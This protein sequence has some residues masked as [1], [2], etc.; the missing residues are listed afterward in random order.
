M[1][2]L[3]LRVTFIVRSFSLTRLFNLRPSLFSDGDVDG[4]SV[5]LILWFSSEVEELADPR[6]ALV[7]RHVNNFV[8]FVLD[9]QFGVYFLFHIVD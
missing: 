6:G 2:D 3:L 8:G 1:L 5:L 4:D 7:A 9:A